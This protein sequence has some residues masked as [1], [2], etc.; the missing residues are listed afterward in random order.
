MAVAD[1]CAK[2]RGDCSAVGVQDLQVTA[3]RPEEYSGAGI[4][5]QICLHVH[6]RVRVHTHVPDSIA[7]HSDW[8]WQSSS[9]M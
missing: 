5:R 4:L 3:G 9:C 6:V 1:M 8:P 7:L 2:L